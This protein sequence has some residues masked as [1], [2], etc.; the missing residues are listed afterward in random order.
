MCEQIKVCGLI[1][2]ALRR[3]IL[4]LSLSSWGTSV[5]AETTAL[6][7]ET[8]FWSSPDFEISAWDLRMYLKPNVDKDGEILWGTGDQVRRALTD[9]Y[10]LKVLDAEARKEQILSEDQAR[11][12]AQYRVAMKRVELL[13]HARAMEMMEGTDWDQ[14][15]REYFKANREEFVEAETIR[16]R[17]LLLTLNKRTLD[18]ALSLAKELAPK[19]LNEA[20]FASVVSDKSEEPSG[21]DGLIDNLV[22]GQTVP[23]FE[24][25]AFR[26]QEVGD[27]SDPVVS[28]FGVHVIQLL[29]RRPERLKAF[30]EIREDL[31]SKLQQS[32]WEEFKNLVRSEPQSAPPAG[33][34]EYQDNIDAVI[35]LAEEQEINR[36]KTLYLQGQMESP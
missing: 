16:V 18:Q 22:R 11:W 3:H 26:L 24:Q 14:R 19:T 35:Q 20:Q 7:D 10:T 15:A 1:W 32:D 25:A 29:G 31:A 28:P 21:G 2:R 30:E 33:L 5:S 34:R 17:T 12:I 9:L 36:R 8:L 4:L 13:I 6:S 23:E 27:I